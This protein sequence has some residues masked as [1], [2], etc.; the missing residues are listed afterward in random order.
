MQKFY[1]KGPGGEGAGGQGYS[2]V[3]QGGYVEGGHAGYGEGGSVVCSEG[4]YDYPRYH[5]PQNKVRNTHMEQ[6]LVSRKHYKKNM[7]KLFLLII[8]IKGIMIMGAK[9]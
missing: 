2:E 5:R 7:P 4:G 3:G 1:W 9:W 8:C 6:Q